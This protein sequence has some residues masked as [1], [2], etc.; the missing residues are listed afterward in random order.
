MGLVLS[1]DVCPPLKNMVDFQITGVEASHGIIF[2][3]SPWLLLIA[4]SPQGILALCVCRY[5]VWKNLRVS[6][7][8]V[9]RGL[10]VN[11]SLPEFSVQA[12]SV[13]DQIQ[14]LPGCFGPNRTKQQLIGD[15]WM[16]EWMGD[17]WWEPT[18]NSSFPFGFYSLLCRVTLSFYLSSGGLTVTIILRQV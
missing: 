11:P 15:G 1:G 13:S 2:I 5:S 3:S 9:Y 17:G 6:V 14:K 16:N 18:G 8:G 4:W 12:V 7:L 10:H